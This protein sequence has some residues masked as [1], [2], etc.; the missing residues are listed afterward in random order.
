VRRILRA[1][2]W[3]V[4]LDPVVGHEQGGE[5]PALVISTEA[6]NASGGD[7]VFIV[8][9]TSKFHALRTRVH[10]AP[11]EGGLELDS[12]ILCDKLRSLSQ[13]RLK[14]RIGCVSE[15]TMAQV[16]DIVGKILDL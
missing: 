8:P 5:R 4:G 7:D 11:P 6:F 1:E 12:Y 15:K 14:N 10:I 2:V 16:E 9:I 3:I 13:R